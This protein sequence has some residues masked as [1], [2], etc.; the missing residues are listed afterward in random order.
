MRVNLRRASRFNAFGYSFCPEI[1]GPLADLERLL[2]SADA[3]N[4]VS[5]TID[6]ARAVFEHW[7]AFLVERPFSGDCARG[8]AEVVA[9]A[10]KLRAYLE[11][12]GSAPDQQRPDADNT[13][14]DGI[15]TWLKVVAIGGVAV[16]LLGYISPFIPRPKRMGDY[17]SDALEKYNAALA[18]CKDAEERNLSKATQNKR[19][20]AFFA[21]ENALKKVDIWRHR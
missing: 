21:A 13:V 19:W 4:L 16:L 5:L 20:K 12:I 7:D 15:P 9:T 17:R 14:S 8:T 3:Q 6:S 11:K 10:A 18:A 1:E 2:V